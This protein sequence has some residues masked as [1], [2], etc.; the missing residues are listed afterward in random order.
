MSNYEFESRNEAEQYLEANIKNIKSIFPENETKLIVNSLASET[1]IIRERKLPTGLA[2]PVLR[3]RFVIKDDDLQFFDSIFTGILSS[4]SAGFFLSGNGVTSTAISSS[5]LGVAI[6]IFKLGRNAYNKR[7]QIEERCFKVLKTIYSNELTFDELLSDLEIHD[8]TW[9]TE[10]LESTL[11]FLKEI[12][13]ND[14][15]PKQLVT[16]TKDKKWRTS[17]I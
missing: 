2:P 5:I 12:P 17:G 3:K 8:S 1:D 14:G 13:S 6:A 7:I 9:T 16:Q 11:D 4:A 10:E 15:T